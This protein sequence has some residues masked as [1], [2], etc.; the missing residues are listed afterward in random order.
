MT[1]AAQRHEQIAMSKNQ[2]ATALES[3]SSSQASSVLPSSSQELGV[4]EDTQSF[5][6]EVSEENAKK[7]EY[8]QLD[9][10]LEDIK[11]GEKGSETDGGKA[12]FT[13]SDIEIESELHS[14]QML[15]MTDD[16]AAV[17]A[18]FGVSSLNSIL[19][20]AFKAPVSIPE[21]QQEQLAA[22]AM[23][24][25]RKYYSGENTPEWVKKYLD[26]IGFG[27]ALGTALFGCY[28]QA[29]V[30]KLNVKEEDETTEQFDLPEAA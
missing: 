2:V 25:V 3:V 7:Y 21:E 16:D 17:M 6:A 12:N 9:D 8:T 4:N 18:S 11:F 29:K 14:A 22:K 28:Q 26:E 24:L 15:E 23:P 19:P 5:T 27:L 1:T 10:Y 13:R 30:H 20:M